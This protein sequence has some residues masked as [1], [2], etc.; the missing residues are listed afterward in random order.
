MKLP[1]QH[2]PISEIMKSGR[3][4]VA[5]DLESHM[6]FDTDEPLLNYGFLS[7]IDLPLIKQGQLIGAIKFFVQGKRQLH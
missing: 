5:R 7:Y 2:H 3:P 6:G 4:Y 1:V